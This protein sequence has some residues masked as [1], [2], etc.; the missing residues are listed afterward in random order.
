MPDDT[1]DRG[2]Q[3]LDRS[4]HRSLLDRTFTISIILKGLDGLLEMVGGLL[5]LLV[6]ARTWHSLALAL[7][8][9][10]LSQD[11]H[12][13]IANHLLHVTSRLNQT[14]VFGAVYLLS[15]GAV[16]VVLVVAL[17]RRQWWAYPVTIAFLVAF[18]AYQLYRISI[19][20]T[21]GMIALTVFDLCVTWLVW[22]EYQLHRR[23]RG[24]LGG[25]VT[26]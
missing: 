22:R 20:P 19:A 2:A 13:Y 10:E 4:A 9:H 25:S 23:A 11:P 1:D 12:D 5:L 16:K 8:R 15:H 3:T 24:D 26:A 21:A 7:T 17:L 14:R 6:S 18:I